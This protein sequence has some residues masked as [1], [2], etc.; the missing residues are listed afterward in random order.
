[1][2]WKKKCTSKGVRRSLEEG[3]KMAKC[4]SLEEGIKEV[5]TQE[6]K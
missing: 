5:E 2:G 3:V 6:Y 4:K 1:M